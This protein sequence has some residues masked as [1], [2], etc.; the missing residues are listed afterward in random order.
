MSTTWLKCALWG[1]IPSYAMSVV[2]ERRE[3]LL[4][5]K[6]FNC[7]QELFLLIPLPSGIRYMLVP[8]TRILFGRIKEDE[9]WRRKKFWTDNVTPCIFKG[10]GQ[11]WSQTR[12]VL[13]D[14]VDLG[15][16]DLMW[17]DYIDSPI[18]PFRDL[19]EQGAGSSICWCFGLLW[20]RTGG[21]QTRRLYSCLHTWMGR[22]CTNAKELY[23]WMIL[24][25]DQLALLN[26][27]INFI[28]A[29]LVRINRDSW[30]DNYQFIILFRIQ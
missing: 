12:Q 17:V 4:L 15:L 13:E 26:P 7:N 28:Y 2:W 3:P 11:L 20:S 19:M 25:L 27:R 8:V 14:L 30:T 29:L 22:L 9:E 21:H 16:M 10:F 18:Q 1:T 6:W 24:N 5:N 23:Q